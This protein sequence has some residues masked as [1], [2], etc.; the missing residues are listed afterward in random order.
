VANHKSALKRIK[1]N[2]RRRLRNQRAKSD[3]RTHIK[4]VRQSISA[5]DKPAAAAG[6]PKAIA[7]LSSAAG[8]GI[9]P[10]KRASRLTSRLT[11]AVNTIA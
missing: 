11:K 4:L 1:Q 3:V 8:K 7:K 9:I 5:G 10:K 2:E 6:L